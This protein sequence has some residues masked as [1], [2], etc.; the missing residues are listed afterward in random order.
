MVE[1]FANSGDRDQTLR[2][3]IHPFRG[4]Q[5]T[6]GEGNLVNFCFSLKFRRRFLFAFKETV[7]G[8]SCREKRHQ[9]LRDVSTLKISIGF[10]VIAFYFNK[11]GS[12]SDFLLAFLH[13]K[14]LLKGES[15]Y[16]LLG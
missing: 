7:L 3:A 16:F 15:N 2:S 5:T 6:M 8:E 1:L 9:R 14:S 10:T 12:S 13:T 11:G 4:L